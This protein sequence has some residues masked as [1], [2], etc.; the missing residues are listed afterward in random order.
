MG[1]G[2]VLLNSTQTSAFVTV[3]CRCYQVNAP[4]VK[5]SK[6][7]LRYPKSYGGKVRLRKRGTLYTPAPKHVIPREDKNSPEF[8]EYQKLKAKK[9]FNLLNLEIATISNSSEAPVSEMIALYERVHKA[10]YVYRFYSGI[11][12]YLLDRCDQQNRLDYIKGIFT[13]FIQ[14]TILDDAQKYPIVHLER[15]WNGFLGILSDRGM[16]A[17][18]K[19][20]YKA[21][22]N[23][24]IC[25]SVKSSQHLITMA[26][27]L[28][29][30][31][32]ASLFLEAMLSSNKRPS[33]ALFNKL[34][35]TCL[36]ANNETDPLKVGLIRDMMKKSNAKPNG[37]TL[38]IELK[39]STTFEDIENVWKLA[40]ENHLLKNRNFHVAIIK[41][42]VRVARKKK[43]DQSSLIEDEVSK[44]MDF[45]FRIENHIKAT[46]Q[47]FP[48]E[49]NPL[50]EECAKRYSVS[51]AIK[52]LEKMWSVNIDPK[53]NGYKLLLDVL[54]NGY[55]QQGSQLQSHQHLLRLHHLERQYV[56]R[57]LN[58]ILRSSTIKII[59]PQ[60]YTSILLS[61][62]RVGDK[63]AI[64][65]FFDA[66]YT[67][68]PNHHLD[69]ERET[70][71]FSMVVHDITNR[72]KNPSLDIKLSNTF[73]EAISSLAFDQGYPQETLELY[74]RLPEH[75]VQTEF[76]AHCLFK[77]VQ[78]S[79]QIHRFMIPLIRA[80][81]KRNPSS[82]VD[83]LESALWE[84]IRNLKNLPAK[85]FGYGKLIDNLDF[86]EMEYSEIRLLIFRAIAKCLARE[87]SLIKRGLDVENC[88]QIIEA[89]A[90]EK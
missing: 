56:W 23:H 39:L 11:V 18:M 9:A 33:I 30:L 87:V 21:M 52:L 17:E 46:D 51:Q 4:A 27:K 75:L 20:V 15:V 89:W 50:L 76:A 36:G 43:H 37:K 34:L 64:L 1:S 86:D 73:M 22:V 32:L 88:T 26:V 28:G 8:F 47:R 6:T 3:G 70:E 72:S 79:A 35:E 68:D 85:D 41:A 84:M 10:C 29:H 38:E 12:N 48:V 59:P 44:F 45:F 65:D 58:Q 66:R 54:G 81:I 16:F 57:I 63:S 90:T 40:T 13:R 74:N 53:K 31:D 2:Q 83:L 62:G 19:I 82:N 14:L 60:L 69:I 71:K 49:F 42:C 77:S 80:W 78:T 5:F 24:D 55:S 67:N 25:F 7:E 61:L